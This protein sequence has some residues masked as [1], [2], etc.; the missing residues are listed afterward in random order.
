MYAIIYAEPA[1]NRK[2]TANQLLNTSCFSLTHI[3]AR[4]LFINKIAVGHK[5]IYFQGMNWAK[6][7]VYLSENTLPSE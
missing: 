3:P 4:I 5:L 6:E 7:M 2:Q 1:L